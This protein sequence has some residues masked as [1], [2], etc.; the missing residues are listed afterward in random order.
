MGISEAA[1][2]IGFKSMGVKA[3]LKQSFTQEFNFSKPQNKVL[4]DK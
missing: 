3:S 2:N 1:E 4:N